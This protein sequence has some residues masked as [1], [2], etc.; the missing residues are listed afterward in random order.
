VGDRIAVTTTDTAYEAK[1]VISTLPPFLLQSSVQFSPQLSTEFI[2]VAKN[3]HTWMGDSIKVGLRYATPFWRAADKSGTI[4]SNVGPIPEM[5]DHTNVEENAY[6]L[7]GFFNGAYY[8]VNVE[9]RKAMVLTQLEKYYGPR[10]GD[11]L[12]YQETVWRNEPFTFRDYDNHVLPHQHNGH[13]IFRQAYWQGKLLIAGSET[14]EI[15]PGYMDGAVSSAHRVV[16]QLV[17]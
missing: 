11:Y 12:D 16:D 13:P 6:A 8:S 5:Y 10:V 4:F 14:A 17:V 7:K 2:Q 15:H 9:Q 1:R 3:T